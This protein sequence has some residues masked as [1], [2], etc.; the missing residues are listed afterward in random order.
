MQ[1]MGRSGIQGTT[2]CPH[3]FND[4]SIRQS[5]RDLLGNP[6]GSGKWKSVILFRLFQGPKRYSDLNGLMPECSKRMLSLQLK[7][8]ERDKIIYRTVMPSGPIIV[9]YSVT[10]FGNT[11]KPIIEAMERWGRFYNTV[12][13]HQT[14]EPKYM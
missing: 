4:T 13:R 6:L 8:L 11:L 14:L 2:L 9:Y 7:E 3:P 12:S 1:K 10:K 5:K